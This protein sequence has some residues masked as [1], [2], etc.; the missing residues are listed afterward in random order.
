MPVSYVG[1]NVVAVQAFFHAP[2]IGATPAGMPV[3]SG[4]T[5]SVGGPL[6]LKVVGGG[7]LGGQVP[8]LVGKSSTS[9]FFNAPDVV[10]PVSVDETVEKYRQ[11]YAAAGGQV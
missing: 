2:I 11:S 9:E 8:P 4:W 10:K 7:V 5:G 6:F 1:T 3:A